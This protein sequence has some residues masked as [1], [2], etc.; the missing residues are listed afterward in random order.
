MEKLDFRSVRYKK[1]HI[2]GENDEVI[3]ELDDTPVPCIKKTE[4]EAKEDLVS[5]NILF[6]KDDL[7]K[8]DTQ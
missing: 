1:K 3:S 2:Y 4:S 6:G 8:T 7:Q 5:D